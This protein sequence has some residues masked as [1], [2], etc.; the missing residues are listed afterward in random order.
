MDR[1][2]TILMRSYLQEKGL[3]NFQIESFNDFVERRIP[4]IIKSIGKIRPEIPEIGELEIKLGKF[5]LGQPRVKEFDGSIRNI[6]PMEARMRNLTYAA[7]MYVEM[8]QVLNGIESRPLM[9]EIGDLPVMVKSKFCPLSKMSERELIEAGEDPNDPGGYFII[10]GTERILMLI[11]E[12]ATD[13]IIVEKSNEGSITEK[14]RIHSEKEG[15]I[16][17]H[18]LERKR[19]GEIYIT[20]ANVLRIPIVIILKA[21]GLEKDK[22]LVE[23]ISLDERI[24]EAFLINVLEYPIKD[25]NEAIDELGKFLRIPQKSIRKKQAIKMIDKYLLPHLGQ[26]PENRLTK[27]FFLAKTV[28]K[29]IKLHFGLIEEDDVDHYANKRIKMSG[30]LL[31][32]LLRSILLGKWGLVVRMN[33]NYQKLTKRGKL[34]PL[35]SVVEN[36]ILT[37]QIISAMAVGTWIGGRTGVTQRLERSSWTKTN[38]HMRSVVSP[39]SSSQEHFEARELHPTHFGKL[40]AT[41]TPEG[42]NIGLRKYLA[43]SAS[44]T[45]G[46]EERSILPVIRNLMKGE[47]NG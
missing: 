5:E 23:A 35:Q 46:V 34:P 7:P 30:D 24:Q 43:I 44:I 12:I 37:N 14:A 47:E 22:D 11:E 39:L 33:Y 45:T 25:S 8:T 41:Q 2:F 42:A 6:L 19:T 38:T 18:L 13:R 27:A 16:Q 10:G 26:E 15:F 1:I 28:E 9:I 4:K 32:L 31:E 17:K 36:T 3:V 40:C 20:F 29:M 21:L